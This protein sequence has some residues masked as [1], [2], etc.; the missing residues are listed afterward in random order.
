MTGGGPPAPP[1]PVAVEGA[2]PPDMGLSV[3]LLGEGKGAID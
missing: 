1:E 3:E 2:T